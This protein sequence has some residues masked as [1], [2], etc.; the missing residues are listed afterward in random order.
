[1]LLQLGAGAE[2]RGELIPGQRAPAVLYNQS[3]RHG[4]LVL[5]IARQLYVEVAPKSGRRQLT[6]GRGHKAAASEVVWPSGFVVEL[7]KR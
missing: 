5:S 1:M 7:M 2:E 4:S 6:E 3:S